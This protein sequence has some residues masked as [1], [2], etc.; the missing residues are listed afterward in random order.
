MKKVTLSLL[1]ALATVS[2]TYSQNLKIIT[3]KDNNSLNDS[4]IYSYGLSSDGEFGPTLYVINTSNS[5]SLTVNVK[6]RIIDTV[7]GS[8][9]EICWAGYCYGPSVNQSPNT[10]NIGAGD[11]AKLG[12]QFNGDYLPN[13]HIGTTTI[14]Y[15]FF[16]VNNSADTAAITVIYNATLTGIDNI[17]SGAINFSTPYPNPANGSANFS[18]T[19]TNGVQSANL[20]IFNLIG[21]CVQTLPLSALKSKATIDV[22]AMPSGIY[23]CEMQANGYRPVYQ[24]LV[25]SH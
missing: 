7:T 23:I 6:R 12:E 13:G 8:Q 21:E 14:R 9:N 25:V 18:Y 11:T 3:P 16:D 1:F 2:F 5:G 24:R 10:E 20:K 22:G 15:I 19:L 17:T 4:T